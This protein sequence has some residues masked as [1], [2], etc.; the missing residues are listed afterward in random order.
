MNID[1]DILKFSNITI[2]FYFEVNE[3]FGNVEYDLILNNG[4]DSVHISDEDS[5]EVEIDIDYPPKELK[6][7]LIKDPVAPDN[8]YPNLSNST[9][10]IYQI[11]VNDQSIEF[12]ANISIKYSQADID[13]K[14]LNEWLITIFTYTNGQWVEITDGFLDT[15][16][17]VVTVEVDHFS[18]FVVMQGVTGLDSD[19]DG[20]TDNV[21]VNTYG[22][23][24][25]DWDSDDDGFSDGE[26]IGQG[27][28]P[29][30]PN[31]YPI[32]GGFPWLIIII[33]V[34]VEI[35]VGITLFII[36]RKKPKK[37]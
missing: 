4:T 10:I 28:N 34:V 25:N 18:Y 21:E 3:S 35:A 32:Q 22:T 15:D 27:T 6:T 36:L 23:D 20:L 24:P 5:I 1:M 16:D 26:E 11:E 8:N 7:I 2:N 19:N 14:G 37:E 13:S 31:D 9:G 17:N 33:I 12:N 29:N 30:D